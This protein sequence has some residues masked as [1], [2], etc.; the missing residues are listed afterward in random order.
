MRY[1]GAV[2]RIDDRAGGTRPIVQSPY[3][4]SNGQVGVR[5]VAPHRGEHNAAV[6][7][8]WLRCGDDEVAELLANGVLLRDG[9]A[10]EEPT[11]AEVRT[12]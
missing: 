5:G 11:P 2:I 8:D 9:Q 10:T 7:K 1:R 4:F 3:R 12:T 6:L